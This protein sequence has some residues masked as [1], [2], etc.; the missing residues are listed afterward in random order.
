MDDK[1]AISSPGMG[2]PGSDLIPIDISGGDQS[3][4]PPARA[5][6]C[7]PD[8][9]AGAVVLVTFAGSTRTTSVDPGSILPL[10]FVSVVSSGTTATGLEAIV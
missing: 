3:F 4:D 6:R 8:G 2:D 9:E 10:A 5:L 7:K 1:T